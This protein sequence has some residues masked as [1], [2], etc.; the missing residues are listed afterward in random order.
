[1]QYTC[2][3][4][5]LQ[6]ILNNNNNNNYKNMFQVQSHL[7][8]RLQTDGMGI[9]NHI[10]KE[11]V[12]TETEREREKERERKRKRERKI[13]CSHFP[14]PWYFLRLPVCCVRAH[15]HTLTH[16]HTHTHTQT[17]TQT[18]KRTPTPSSIHFLHPNIGTST[19]LADSAQCSRLAKGRCS[20]LKTPT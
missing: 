11:R 5:P 7:S 3:L 14:L 1:M 20:E 13:M 15:T 8:L 9:I 6:H 10:R 19:G 16:T 2:Y 12:E 4:S 18:Y 17:Y